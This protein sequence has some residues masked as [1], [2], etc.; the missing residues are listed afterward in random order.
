[1]NRTAVPLGDS[2]RDV[3]VLALRIVG[4]Y[5]NDRVVDAPKLAFGQPNLATTYGGTNAAA[6]ECGVTICTRVAKTP[7]ARMRRR[8]PPMRWNDSTVPLS[9]RFQ[10]RFRFTASSGLF[11]EVAFVIPRR[12]RDR[13]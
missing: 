13:A 4:F 3:E 12:R 2:R 9:H 6:F 5:A 8:S 1:M 7:V 10:S 11:G